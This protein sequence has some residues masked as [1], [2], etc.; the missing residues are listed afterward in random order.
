MINRAAVMLKYKQTA[1][2]WINEVDPKPSDNITLE[3]VN[4]ERTVYLVSH[5]DADS[6]DLVNRWVK[7]NYKALFENELYAWYIDD[8]LWPKKRSFKVFQE[9][10]DIECHTMV[11]DTVGTPIFDEDD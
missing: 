4:Q 9:W 6:P 2:D 7:A 11:E 1:V 10:F 3:S 5:E 8:S